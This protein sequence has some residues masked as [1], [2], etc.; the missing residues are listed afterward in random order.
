VKT[1]YTPN[2]IEIPT[3]EVDLKHHGVGFEGEVRIT[4]RATVRWRENVE[5]KK[6][7]RKK[8]KGDVFRELSRA[9]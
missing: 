6:V 7:G 2:T 5:R 3:H 4:N 9:E 1:T 8:E